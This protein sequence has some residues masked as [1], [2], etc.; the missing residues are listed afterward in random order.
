MDLGDM[1]R[2]VLVTRTE[3]GD[4]LVGRSGRVLGVVR[5]GADGYS[6]YPSDPAFPRLGPFQLLSDAVGACAEHRCSATFA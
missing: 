3:D 6:G 5:M 1:E 2:D 4:F